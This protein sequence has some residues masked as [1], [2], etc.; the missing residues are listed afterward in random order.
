MEKKVV[1]RLFGDAATAS[2]SVLG[3][4]HWSRAFSFMDN[5]TAYVL[6]IGEHRDDFE[7]DASAAAFADAFLPIPS[8]VA[9][10]YD[11]R[12]ISA[13]HFEDINPLA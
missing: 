7:K 1:G 2:M 12:F 11:R 13:F 10:G 8:V 9:I 4:G 3:N 6:R 5:G